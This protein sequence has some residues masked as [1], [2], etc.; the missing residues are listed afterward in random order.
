MHISADQK[1]SYEHIRLPMLHIQL[2][3]VTIFQMINGYAAKLHLNSTMQSQLLESLSRSQ[4]F[5]RKRKDECS[6]VSLRDV[7]RTLTILEWLHSKMSGIL[8]NRIYRKVLRETG[9]NPT[10]D[11]EL[12]LI[13]AL[14]VSYYT[15]LDEQRPEYERQLTDILHL[16]RLFFSRVVVACQDIFVDELKLELNIAK[17]EALKENIWMMVICIELKIPLFLVGKPGSSK[18]LAKSLVN[19]VMQGDA[20]YSKHL[21]KVV[22]PNIRYIYKPHLRD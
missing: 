22:R 14:G 20:S 3:E 12:C 21:F 7:E 15:R 1:V 8:L 18:S 5:M 11:F 10:N 2:M 6:F 9:R 16:D 13:L 19:G 17:N 4:S